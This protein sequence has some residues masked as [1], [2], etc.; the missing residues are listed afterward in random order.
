MSMR[1]IV[2]PA[3]SGLLH[4]HF[5]AGVILEERRDRC[6]SSFIGLPLPCQHAHEGRALALVAPVGKIEHLFVAND[7]Q[8]GDKRLQ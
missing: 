6:L 3:G 1:Q 7:A 2:A 8:R 4:F 5:C